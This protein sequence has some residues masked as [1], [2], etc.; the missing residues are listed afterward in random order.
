MAIVQCKVCLSFICPQPITDP[1]T[2]ITLSLLVDHLQTIY[3]A[4][5]HLTSLIFSQIEK[6]K[7]EIRD[8]SKEV[9]EDTIHISKRQFC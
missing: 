3:G 8:V 2:K 5:Q 9:P 7:N 1:D 4:Y 6:L